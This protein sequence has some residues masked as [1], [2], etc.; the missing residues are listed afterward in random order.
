MKQCV[1]NPNALQISYI[2]R[3]IISCFVNDKMLTD[4]TLINDPLFTTRM[5]L[6]AMFHYLYPAIYVYIAEY[7]IYL[8]SLS[9][10]SLSN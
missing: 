7:H 10:I 5:E 2:R 9:I 3:Q 6:V 8:S 1:I 4:R